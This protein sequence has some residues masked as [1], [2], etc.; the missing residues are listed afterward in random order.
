MLHPI[1]GL[2]FGIFPIYYFCLLIS[3]VAGYIS[4]KRAFRRKQY[5]KFIYKRIKRSFLYSALIGLI[6]SN[7]ITWIVHEDIARLA[8]TERITEGGYSVYF[9]LL[10]FFA[11]AFVLLRLYGLDRVFCINKIA[12]VLLIAHSFQE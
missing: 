10:G 4:F 1:F 11:A 5:S 6:S 3:L 8:L 9:G 7:V 2:D 12:R